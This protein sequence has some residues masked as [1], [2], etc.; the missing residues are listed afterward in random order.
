MINIT[1]IQIELANLWEDVDSIFEMLELEQEYVHFELA[2]DSVFETLFK[3]LAEIQLE[4]H[5]LDKRHHSSHTTATGD[6][7]RSRKREWK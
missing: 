3:A 2:E 5:V 4:P 1:T 7:A 6:V